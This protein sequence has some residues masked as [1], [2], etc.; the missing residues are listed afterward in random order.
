MIFFPEHIAEKIPLGRTNGRV[1]LF[2]Q[3][4]WQAMAYISDKLIIE[5]G[6]VDPNSVFPAWV[7]K[8]IHYGMEFGLAV[9]VLQYKDNDGRKIGALM[10]LRTGSLKLGYYAVKYKKP[11]EMIPV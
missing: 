2:T 7:M 10:L 11:S 4:Q 9:D 5:D 1:Y 3:S 6:F 8:S